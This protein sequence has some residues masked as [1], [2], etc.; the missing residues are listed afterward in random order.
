[1]AA[2]A[3]DEKRFSAMPSSGHGE[4]A[5]SA[6]PRRPVGAGAVGT[7]GTV[8]TARPE[9]AGPSVPSAFPG[10]PPCPSSFAQSDDLKLLGSCLAVTAVAAHLPFEI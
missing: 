3:G 6:E 10:A 8:G 1:M 7:V 5:P 9:H 2:T 4:A